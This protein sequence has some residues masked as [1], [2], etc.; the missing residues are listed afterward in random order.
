[1]LVASSQSVD[2]QT[3][4]PPSVLDAASI[5]TL[6]HVKSGD[7]SV[8]Q[9]AQAGLLGLSDQLFLRTSVEPARPVGVD[10]EVDDLSVYPLLYWPLTDMTPIPSPDAILRLK[11]YLAAGG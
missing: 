7:P 9:V 10:V 4:T 1:M 6:A 11:R 8:D 5:V 2:A 3:D